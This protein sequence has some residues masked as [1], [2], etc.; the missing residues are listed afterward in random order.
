MKQK[1]KVLLVFALIF[2]V[3][4]ILFSSIIQTRFGTIKM[5]EVYLETDAG[6]L[7]LY[8]FKPEKATEESPAPCVVLSPG[9]LNNK[10]MQDA[11][12]VEL[13]RRGYVVIVMD[14]YGHGNSDLADETYQYTEKVKSGGM[15]DCVFFASTL[16]YVDKTQIG[17]C[18]HSMGGGYAN[19]TMKYFTDLERAAQDIDVD[20]LD[21]A[22]MLNLVHTGVIIGNYPNNILTDNPRKGYLCNI[23]VIL[24]K[25][26]EFFYS[27]G[28]DLLT[29]EE[30]ADI[31]RY[32]AGQ[33]D[34]LNI[35][36][37]NLYVNSDTGYGIVFYNP[38]E[39]HATNHFSYTVVKD[40]LEIF[41]HTMPAPRTLA[42]TDQIWF[43]KE[44]CQ[45][46]GLIGFFMFIVPFTDAVLCLPFFAELRKEAKPLPTPEK[47]KPYIG[48]NI[49]N[50]ILCFL[51]IIPMF[52]LGYV[53][54]VNPVFP[55]DTTGGIGLWS[56]ACGLVLWAGT[57]KLYGDKLSKH[58]KEL[59]IQIGTRA[60]WKTVLLAVTVVVVTFLFLGLAWIFKTDFRFWTFDVRAFNFRKVLVALRYL[61]LFFV[62]YYFQSLA[63]SRTRFTL[64]SEAK[65]MRIG[66]LWSIAP[67]VLMLLITYVPA[68]GGNATLWIRLFPET[69]S[70]AEIARMAM[71]LIPILLIPFVPILA[72]SSRI[73]IK[74]NNLTD[75][76][77]LG[78]FIN[79]MM[80]TM[81]T[82]SNT[83][84]SYAY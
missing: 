26:D 30:T 52:G 39:F 75:Q 38:T 7:C 23:G 34:V 14:A 17:V 13:A 22:H 8:L 19:T 53:A 71:A 36:E 35:R 83:S 5:Q 56:V 65:Q 67:V 28:N 21:D 50:T 61:P 11:N 42:S 59:G 70:L 77:W 33:F 82:V 60:F 73:S 41:E 84:F 57:R 62:F 29:S 6:T 74:L 16:P 9:Y 54:L 43:W 40:M 31:V 27:Y 66:A 69:W 25:S 1:N 64:W 24:A 72:I 15:I 68:L 58:K 63:L 80:I 10:E 48:R 32:H 2:M 46:I 51:L 20:G 76:V 47:W 55:Q 18:G 44:L 4:G 79:S 45:L 49:L 3:L 37:G 81:I 78:A 12:Y